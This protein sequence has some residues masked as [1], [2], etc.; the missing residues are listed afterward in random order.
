MK[1]ATTTLSILRRGL[2]QF[3]GF[4]LLFRLLGLAVFIPSTAWLTSRLIAWSGSGAVSNYDL[5]SFFLSLKG[6][7]YLI[8]EVTIGFALAFF[9]FGGLTALAISLQRRER[10][11]MR[12]LFGFLGLALPRLWRLSVKQFLIYL[13]IALPFLALA[14][15]AYLIFLTENDI[16]YYLYAKPPPFWIALSVCIVAGLG[17]AF[18]AVRRFVR[19]IYSVPLLL[20]T[21]ASPLAALRESTEL[22]RTRKRETVVMLLRWLVLVALLFGASWLLTRLLKWVLLG[23]AGNAP[24]VVLTMTALLVVVHFLDKYRG[25]DPVHGGT[26]LQGFAAVFAA[27]AGCHPAGIAD[28]RGDGARAPGDGIPPHRMG[29]ACDFHCPDNLR[30]SARRERNPF[31]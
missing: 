2:P 29:S 14:G 12:Q 28:R 13:V 3:A 18:F 8:V 30:Y 16:N 10:I 24:A 6:L 15:G 23:A 20:F 31:A 9:E 4:E 19:W 25:G 26:G 7:C 21:S 11:R 1:P 17:F 22:V 27:P 5:A